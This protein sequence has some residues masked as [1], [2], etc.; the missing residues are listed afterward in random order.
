VLIGRSTVDGAFYQKN[1]C[2][3][4]GT[5]FQKYTALP[6]E[7]SGDARANLMEAIRQAGGSGKAKLRSAKDMKIEAKKKKQVGHQ[8]I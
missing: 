7:N 5:L 4:G 1:V 6:V 3:N 2:V 8:F